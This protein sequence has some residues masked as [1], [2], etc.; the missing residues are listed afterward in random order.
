MILIPHFQKVW[1]LNVV[2][3]SMAISQ[4]SDV[5]VLF[6]QFIDVTWRSLCGVHTKHDLLRVPRL[7]NRS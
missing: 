4:H 6:L 3:L 2:N 1:L 5:Y 7:T